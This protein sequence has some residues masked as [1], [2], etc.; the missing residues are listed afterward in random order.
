MSTDD[1]ERIRAN[2]KAMLQKV[3]PKINSA[4]IEATRA[5][6]VFHKKATAVANRSTASREQ[7]TSTYSQ[8]QQ[9]Y[10]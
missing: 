10:S 4:G 8:A 5:F 3:P 6:M 9:Y 1:L 2:L 7:L